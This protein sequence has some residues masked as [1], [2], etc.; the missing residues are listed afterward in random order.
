M[1]PGSTGLRRTD[2]FRCLEAGARSEGPRAVTMHS[3]QRAQPL[4][5]GNQHL[6]TQVSLPPEMPRDTGSHSHSRICL[7]FPLPAELVLGVSPLHVALYDSLC[8]SRHHCLG[9]SVPPILTCPL[10]PFGSRARIGHHPCPHGVEF[11]L[12]LVSW[13]TIIASLS[14]AFSG[15]LIFPLCSSATSNPHS[16]LL[17]RH[18]L[19]CMWP[20]V[21][22]CIF[23]THTLFFFMN[24]LLMCTSDTVYKRK[25]TFYLFAD[26]EVFML[27][28]RCCV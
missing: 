2:R 26:M 12:S 17:P 10:F 15:L 28:P 16:Q 27:V 13:F 9:P 18:P 8:D 3:H 24:V 23:E 22:V 6:T 5:P 19:C 21:F 11:I 20:L 25:S 1:F 14:K 4:L 7:F